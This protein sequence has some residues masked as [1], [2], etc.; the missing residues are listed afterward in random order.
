M[1]L[2]SDP[3]K[4]L[5]SSGICEGRVFA[6]AAAAEILEQLSKGG[7]K[8]DFI[9]PSGFTN[10]EVREGRDILVAQGHIRLD[11]GK[12]HLTA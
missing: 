5:L 10:A 2:S 9:T 7:P 11:C 4:I 12:Y 1:T 3:L 8:E 6:R